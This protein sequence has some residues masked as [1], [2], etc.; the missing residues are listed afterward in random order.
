MAELAFKQQDAQDLL[1]E[2]VSNPHVQSA[3]VF[4]IG[5]HR[6]GRPV[7]LEALGRPQE[8]LVSLSEQIEALGASHEMSNELIEALRLYMVSLGA[9]FSTKASA[10]PV[11]LNLEVAEG[12]PDCRFENSLT[13]VTC[14]GT[15]GIQV[16]GVSGQNVRATISGTATTS[17]AADVDAMFANVQGLRLWLRCEAPTKEDIDGLMTAMEVAL[18]GVA[19][20]VGGSM[21]AEDFKNL[22][23]TLEAEGA[24]TPQMEELIASLIALKKA[25]ELGLSK[26]EIGELIQNISTLIAEGQASGLI[27]ASFIVATAKALGELAANDIVRD[28]LIENGLEDLVASNDNALSVED[29]IA[30]L[31]EQ[32]EALQSIEG[33]DPALGSELQEMI[34]SL[35]E[36]LAQEGADPAVI[37]ESMGEKLMDIASRDDLPQAVFDGIGDMLPEIA[38]LKQEIAEAGLSAL[39]LSNPET[40]LTMLE[41]IAAKIEAGEVDPNDVPPEL[42]AVIE[43]VGGVE[44][45]TQKLGREARLEAVAAAIDTPEGSDIGVAMAAVIEI[46]SDPAMVEQFRPALQESLIKLTDISSDML[47][48][49]EMNITDITAKADDLDIITTSVDLSQTLGGSEFTAPA[50]QLTTAPIALAPPALAGGSG[51]VFSS[52][53]GGDGGGT[54]STAQPVDVAANPVSPTAPTNNPSSQPD[55]K[56][57]VQPKPEQKKPEEQEQE[58][59]K[60]PSGKPDVMPGKDKPILDDNKEDKPQNPSIQEVKPTSVP[61][62]QKGIPDCCK[63]KFKQAAEGGAGQPVHFTPE[64]VQE[65][66]KGMSEDIVKQYGGAEAVGKILE[67]ALP[68]VSVETL[69]K[70]GFERILQDAHKEQQ[71]IEQ[72]GSVP[73][74][75]IT[76][77]NGEKANTMILKY[78]QQNTGSSLGGSGLPSVKTTFHECNGA[79]NHASPVNG[80]GGPAQKSPE[81]PPPAKTLDDK[82]KIKAAGRSYRARGPAPAA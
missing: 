66:V 76:Q 28:F 16:H 29:R 82:P 27:P 70:V 24:L 12:L 74:K 32:L 17:N 44:A 65:I 15:E 45:L 79:C 80:K 22:L 67:T 47:D 38:A 55:N 31:M 8:A 7:K 59:D 6:R 61:E 33:I 48:V 4:L 37:L 35:K 25:E 72:Q 60:K 3:G 81:T 78:L 51:L 30:E 39:D 36:Q 21:S 62:V 5:Q 19:Q 53:S 54:G 73:D 2:S 75:T 57:A 46:M 68:N 52:G 71:I 69:Q 40:M 42:M 20:A 18:S 14:I 50:I 77:T 10:K 43:S 64:Q 13:E 49:D 34:E 9:E 41:D 1:I 23:E 58:A 11:Y 63:D 56:P 26:A